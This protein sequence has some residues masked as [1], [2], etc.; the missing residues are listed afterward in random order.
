MPETGLVRDAPVFL[1]RLL[2]TSPAKSLFKL[3]GVT[4]GSLAFSGEGLA[5]V[6]IDP[7]FAEASGKYI[8][9]NDGRLGAARSSAISHDTSR[10]TKLWRDSLDLV[11][12]KADETPQWAS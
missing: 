7:E 2:R 12:A 5:R 11:G 9:S 8:Q 6:A 3:L 10:A 4:P 1:Q